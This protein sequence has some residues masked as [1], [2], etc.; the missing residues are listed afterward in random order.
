MSAEAPGDCN[1][2]RHV[3]LRN[4]L[5][6]KLLILA[7]VSGRMSRLGNEL[8]GDDAK[9]YRLHVQPAMPSKRHEPFEPGKEISRHLFVRYA[10]LLIYR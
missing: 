8:V 6:R 4:Q 9:Q 7:Y 10:T 3:H 2:R 5:A 1:G